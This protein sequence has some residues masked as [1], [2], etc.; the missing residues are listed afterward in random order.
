MLIER[1]RA[2]IA[3][4]AAEWHRALRAKGFEELAVDAIEF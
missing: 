2:T 1:D 3:T 4:M